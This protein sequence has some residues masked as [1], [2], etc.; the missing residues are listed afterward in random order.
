[1]KTPA[2]I[3]AFKR[4]VERH[5]LP[6][7][8]ADSALTIVNRFGYEKVLK[9][10]TI[11]TVNPEFLKCDERYQGSFI[12]EDRLRQFVADPA[13]QLD[14]LFLDR[15]LGRGDECYGFI[16]GSQLASYGWYSNWPTEIDAD[17]LAVHFDPSYMYMYKGHTHPA[18]RG[19]RLHAVGMTRALESYLSRGL[20]GLVSYVEWNN[21]DSLK[22]CYRMGYRDFGNLYVTRVFGRYFCFSDAGC[23]RYRFRL[24][25]LPE[26]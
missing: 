6:V 23:R 17:G 15:A 4:S 5:G 13:N 18:H 9:G 1:M 25:R 20:K 7:A 11:D 26:W 22:S 16:A 14:D 10:V 24:E 21:F 12:P 2:H 3:E 19:Q 8:L